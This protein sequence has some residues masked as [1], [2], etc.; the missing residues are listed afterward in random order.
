MIPVRIAGLAAA[1]AGSADA[2]AGRLEPAPRSRAATLADHGEFTGALGACAQSWATVL[3]F[4]GPRLAVSHEDM[5]AVVAEADRLL[6]AAA[7]A[8][9]ESR[10]A[11][12]RVLRGLDSGSGQARANAG[13]PLVA[14]AR[15]AAAD[16]EGLAAAFP[17]AH[18]TPAAAG[19][20]IGTVPDVIAALQ[21][22]FG[23]EAMLLDWA[24][25]ENG[26]GAASAAA[27]GPLAAALT[28]LRAA[29][30]RVHTAVVV[31]RDAA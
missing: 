30:L 2:L 19:A 22:A 7:R 10:S 3:R 31:L 16:A 26:C 9:G 18:L 6:D 11:A 25:Q 12:A 17:G 1:S 5:R 21:S 13:A 20:L 4:A 8:A 23:Y 14:A 28:L 29:A 15:L 24:C 27:S